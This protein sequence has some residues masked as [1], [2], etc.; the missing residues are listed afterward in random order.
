MAN[1]AYL[2][3]VNDEDF[4][5]SLPYEAAILGADYSIPPFWL[6]PFDSSEMGQRLDEDGTEV[7]QLVTTKENA[8]ARIAER[9]S[10]GLRILQPEHG[11][12]LGEFVAL[13]QAQPEPFI[14][15]DTFEVPYMFQGGPGWL[16][17]EDIQDLLEEGLTKEEIAELLGGEAE[18]FPALLVS[19]LKAFDS[20]SD[21]D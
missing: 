11:E 18:D 10:S 9:R 4:S 16:P 6:L 2:G 3:A 15:L 7:P 13:I 21:E 19:G 12:F 1:N 8:L 17:E 5:S 20:N 14:R